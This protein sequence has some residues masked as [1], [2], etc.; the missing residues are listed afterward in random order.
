MTRQEGEK[1]NGCM[2][3]CNRNIFVFNMNHL[4]TISLS[5][6]IRKDGE[7]NRKDAKTTLYK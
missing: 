6:R 1:R 2:K 4:E 5:D 3:T 7:V